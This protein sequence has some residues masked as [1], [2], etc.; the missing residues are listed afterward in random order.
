MYAYTFG[1][2]LFPRTNIP[3]HTRTYTH[4]YIYTRSIR[5]RNQ[6]SHPSIDTHVHNITERALYTRVTIYLPP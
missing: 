1:P 5:S 2:S 6:S 4:R 3:V